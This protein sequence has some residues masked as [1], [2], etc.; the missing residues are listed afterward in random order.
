[1]EPALLPRRAA[2]A[3]PQPPHDGAPLR[4]VLFAFAALALVA[5]AGFAGPAVAADGVAAPTEAF[6][7]DQLSPTGKPLPK[8]NKER[9]HV[10]EEKQRKEEVKTK[11]ALD[12]GKASKKKK[13][14]EHHVVGRGADI[15]P[16][17]RGDAAAGTRIVRGDESRRRRGCRV[18]SPRPPRG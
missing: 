10:D 15:S 16:I 11:E 4:S 1:M 17:N 5:F 9:A 3:E 6:L 8:K 7:E 2:P 14:N 18:D 13:V 12:L